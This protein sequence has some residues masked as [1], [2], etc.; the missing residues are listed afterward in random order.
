MSLTF[1]VFFASCGKSEKSSSSSTPKKT[2][3][4]STSSSSSASSSSVSA[5]QQNINTTGQEAYK[6]VLAWYS[7]TA[8]NSTPM[9]QK[10][11]QRLIQ[12][13]A[14]S[15][16]KTDK[17]LGFINIQTC[18]GAS[19]STSQYSSR[20]LT[21]TST[22]TKSSNSKLAAV[23]SP[24]SDMGLV[25]VTQQSGP[26]GKP[27]YSLDYQKINGHIVR[28]KID[29]G[30]NSVFNPVEIYDTEAGTMESVINASQLR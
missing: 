29:S 27:L 13:F 2:S 21:A 4:S 10:L 6:N 26:F 19:A 11:E 17:V 12:N 14:K 24:S 5:V 3:S 1:L 8:E 7:S 15:N 9:G 28:Y 30:L 16:C 23:F 22:T 20:A 25:G 18:F